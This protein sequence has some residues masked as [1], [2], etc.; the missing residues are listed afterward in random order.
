MKSMKLIIN[1][2]LFGCSGNIATN[3]LLHAIFST[4]KPQTMNT[5]KTSIENES[6]PSCLGAVSGSGLSKVKKGT[7][8]YMLV[9]T[10]LSGGVMFCIGQI[11][12][13]DGAIITGILLLIAM[14]SA[15]RYNA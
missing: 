15:V 13:T 7:G 9:S 12:G 6:Q 11:F 8:W 5:E 1:R 10:I 2:Q 3:S 14:A 4:Q